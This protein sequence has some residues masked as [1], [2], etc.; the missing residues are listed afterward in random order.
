MKNSV[1]VLAALLAA[2]SFA[3]RAAAQVSFEVLLDEHQFLAGESMPIAVRLN[4]HSGQ[5]LHFGDETWVSYSVESRDGF[6]VGKHGEVPSGHNFDVESAKMATQ[7]GDLSPYFTIMRPGAYTV[8]ATLHLKDW[9]KEIVSEPAKF[10]I[11]PGTK[12]WEQKFGVPQAAP[13]VGEP[14][15]RKYTLLKAA[16]LKHLR[17]Y[18]RVSDAADTRVIKVVNVGGVVSFS[19]PQTLLD[20]RNNLHLLYEDGARSYNYSVITPDGEVIIRQMH[21]YTDVG[22]RLKFDDLNEVVVVGGMR[23]VTPTDLPEI[24]RPEVST[25]VLPPPHN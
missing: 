6:I 24:K 7:R 23:Q 22:P 15:M 4:N 14:E 5:T 1:L 8:T 21:R 16:Y 9:G 25:N 12:I 19:R 18:L 2:L 20:K 11:V 3:G 10:D 17:L 13:A